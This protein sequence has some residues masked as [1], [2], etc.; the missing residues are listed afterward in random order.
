MLPRFPGDG[1]K[2]LNT[3]LEEFRVVIDSR[4]AGWRL[5]KA[6]QY[7]LPWRSRNGCQQLI[8]RGLVRMADRRPSASRKVRKGEEIWITIPE[9]ARV[10]PD[11]G[12]T[13]DVPVVYEDEWMV[14][15]DKPA[16]LAVHPSGRRLTGTLIHH[17]HARYRDHENPAHDVVPKLMHRIDVETSGV[18][19]VGLQ[20]Q[21]H[22]I[23]TRQFEDREVSKAYLAVVHGGPPEE[24]GLVDLPIGPDKASPVRLKLTAGPDVEGQ[25]S[26]TEY[27]VRHRSRGYSLLEL[28]PRTG[29]THQL[30]VHMEAIGCPLVGD[31]LYGGAED[32]FLEQLDGELSEAS[33]ARLVLDRHA[34]H[35]HRLTFHHP[36]LGAPMTVEAPLPEDM[37]RLME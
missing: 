15:V 29:R 9:E 30:R 12:R 10:A 23:V 3:P 24:A 25:P 14:V 32:I 21:F 4:Q 33:K 18:V 31:K 27:Q 28:R 26:Q 5:D 19:A 11:D 7:F 35:S 17:L 2:D 22:S 6:L 13:L 37:A 20:E 1:P 8:E 36:M 16:G 34:L